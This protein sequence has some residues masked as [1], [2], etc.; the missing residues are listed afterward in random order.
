M[1]LDTSIMNEEPPKW[2]TGTDQTENIS[3]IS[4]PNQTKNKE[5]YL[6]K[7]ECLEA[8]VF[9]LFWGGGGAIIEVCWIPGSKGI[10]V[11]YYTTK[12]SIGQYS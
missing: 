9:P 12:E 6:R 7:G 4:N 11:Y 5:S 1:I 2:Q 10:A 3:C 8:G